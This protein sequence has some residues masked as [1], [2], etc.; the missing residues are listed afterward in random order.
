MLVENYKVALENKKREESLNQRIDV[1]EEE[2]N[3]LRHH[4][5]ELIKEFKHV[6]AKLVNTEQKVELYE[7]KNNEL[8]YNHNTMIIKINSIVLEL[9]DVITVLN[10]KHEENYYFYVCFVKKSLI[11]GFFTRSFLKNGEFLKSTEFLK[12]KEFWKNAPEF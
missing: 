2:N 7:E 5:N 6:V 10:N 3:E 1:L 9:N 8:I 12:N 4:H 11:R